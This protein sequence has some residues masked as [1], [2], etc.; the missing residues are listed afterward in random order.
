MILFVF[1]CVGHL[2]LFQCRRKHKCPCRIHMFSKKEHQIPCRPRQNSVPDTNDQYDKNG[3]F[4][5]SEIPLILLDSFHWTGT[6]ITAGIFGLNFVFM[7]SS[8][9]KTQAG[10]E[11]L[12]HH[13]ADVPRVSAV[14]IKIST[15]RRIGSSIEIFDLSGRIPW[16][17]GTCL[18]PY[19]FEPLRR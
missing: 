13:N 6:R 18:F 15:M 16:S 14:C 7:G 1:S 17:L 10:E 12:F 4:G 19:A 11:I 3:I 9:Q 5:A 8:V 2:S